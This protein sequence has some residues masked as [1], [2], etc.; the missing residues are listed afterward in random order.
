MKTCGRTFMYPEIAK[1]GLDPK[2]ASQF[3]LTKHH[4]CVKCFCARFFYILLWGGM[5]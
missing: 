1:W 5:P 4:A 2:K 3:A